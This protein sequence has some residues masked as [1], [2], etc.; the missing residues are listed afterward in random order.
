MSNFLY[1][2]LYS[3]LRKLSLRRHGGKVL[4]ASAEILLGLLAGIV[5]KGLTLPVSTVC[6]RQQ[7]EED[8][9]DSTGTGRKSIKDVVHDILQERGFLG[10]WAGKW[11]QSRCEA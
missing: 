11:L 7:M 5:S 9:E 10:F 2:G 3:L 8:S 1:F 4:S 6:V